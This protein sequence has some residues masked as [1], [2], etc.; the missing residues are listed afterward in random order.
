[1]NHSMAISECFSAGA[2]AARWTRC[3]P[4]ALILAWMAVLGGCATTAPNT[5]TA[6]T[7]SDQLGAA[8]NAGSTDALKATLATDAV[9]MRGN[10]PALIGREAIV[11]YYAWAF[12]QGQYNL[13]FSSEALEPAG[14]YAVDR[15]TFKATIKAAGA[16]AAVPASGR[17]LHVLVRQPGGG[18]NL[19]RGSWTFAPPLDTTSCDGTGARSCCCKD[20]GGNDCIARPNEGCSSTY[21]IPILLP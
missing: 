8:I 4:F 2:S 19:W 9:L 17:Y 3:G 1:M 10:A 7:L 13:S 16:R 5:N 20:I 6:R 12:K 21:P 11:E 14:S 18:W 15:G